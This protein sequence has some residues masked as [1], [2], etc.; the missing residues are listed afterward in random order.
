MSKENYANK[1]SGDDK[2][3][4]GQL[5]TMEQRLIRAARQTHFRNRE[6]REGI[7]EETSS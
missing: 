5:W 3:W 1:A 6:A 7:S 2:Y 4:E